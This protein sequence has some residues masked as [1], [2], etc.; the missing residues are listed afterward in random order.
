MNN[1]PNNSYDPII[2]KN[3]NSRLPIADKRANFFMN[4]GDEEGGILK[5]L[6]DLKRVLYP[7][8]KDQI[9]L[10][11]YDDLT[12]DTE[13]TIEDIYEFLE[14]ENYAH[15]FNNMKTPHEYNDI[16]GAKDHHTVK[17]NISREE[18]D[19]SKIFLPQTIKKYSGLEFWK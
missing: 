19:L 15:N 3:D 1:D 2:K 5:N 12:R 13:S 16:W 9:L 8:F 7:Q 11:D 6:E 10:V 4:L 17:S 14:I 18:Y